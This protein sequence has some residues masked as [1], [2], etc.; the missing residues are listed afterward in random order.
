VIDFPA[1]PTVGQ[2]F[3]S[4]AQSWTWDGT[5]WVASGAYVG[6]PQY[7]SENRIIN[8]DMRINQRGAATGTASVYTVDRWQ[9]NANQTGKGSWNWIGAPAN[10]ALV[11]IA[12]FGYYLQFISASAYTLLAGDDFNFSQP[13]E[14]D[15][16]VDFAWGTAGAQPVTLSFWVN[17]T[18][19]GTFG[20]CV[21]NAPVPST[22]SYPFSYSIPVANT[23]TKIVV[24]IPGD[25]TGTWVLQGN[26][27]GLYLGFSLGS[28]ATFSGPANTWQA[29]NIHAPT[30]AVSVVATNAATF[31]FTGVKLEVGSAATPFNRPT[32]AKALADCQRYYQQVG[33]SVING[34]SGF[35]NGPLYQT[36]PLPVY[37]RAQPTFSIV[38]TPVYTNCSALTGYS[39]GQPQVTLAITVASTSIL[40]LA[41]FG[42]ALSAEL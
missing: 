30:G 13:I 31:N 19:T 33:Y 26:A 23:W 37:L 17:S 32:L 3:T 27:A 29:G 5:K 9:F 14:A 6:P 16:I 28:G 10:G 7:P 4:G 1:S 2:V 38:G 36:F 34:Y 8:G 12:G 35:A 40:A 11:S 41:T 21:R 18:L 24:T 25:T 39:L 22:R 42:Y 20:G 15:L